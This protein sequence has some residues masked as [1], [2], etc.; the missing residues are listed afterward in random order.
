[1]TTTANITPPH[2]LSLSRPSVTVRRITLLLLLLSLSISQC[3]C[4]VAAAGAA[5][6]AGAYAYY[7]GNHGDTFAGEFGQTY[8]ATKQALADLNMPIR[9]EE[10]HGLTGLIESSIEDGSKVTIDIEEQ[11]RIASTDG[12]VT[13]VKVRVGT[14]GDSQVSSKLHAQIRAHLTQGGTASPNRLPPVKS[15][16]IQQTGATV[17]GVAPSKDNWKPASQTGNSQQQPPP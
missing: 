17:P 6:G 15:Q 13:E 9:H 4:L 3:G 10:H 1:M 16:S 5:A 8:Q 11:P 12:H 2:H 14:F 7:Q